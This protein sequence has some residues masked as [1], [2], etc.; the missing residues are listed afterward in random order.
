MS[1]E[2]F[3]HPVLVALSALVA[4]FGLVLPPSVASAHE[5]ITGIV[6]SGSGEVRVRPDSLR[7]TVSVE[8]QAKT[9]EEAQKQANEQ[10]ARVIA[11]QRAL[12]IPDLQLQTTILSVLPVHATTPEG[13]RLAQIVGY[14]ASNGVSV[15]VRKAPFDKIGG[16]ASAI[17]NAA[18]EAGAN[19][20]G[21]L[22]LFL[23][24]PSRAQAE[25]LTKAVANARHDGEIMAKAAGVTIT[26]TASVSEGEESTPV[27]LRQAPQYE[28]GGLGGS[29]T[30]VEAG[31]IVVSSEVTVRFTIRP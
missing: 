31:E 26:G 23:D 17:L 13:V 30:P 15:A 2:S 27:L 14:S 21:G 18:L 19:E 28:A 25:A 12:R 24:D 4:L 22:E 10:M 20:T 16:Y 6:A 7:I 3:K 8:V 1:H 9:V 5:A 11:S 29:V